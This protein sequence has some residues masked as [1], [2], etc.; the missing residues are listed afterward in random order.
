MEGMPWKFKM[1]KVEMRAFPG[2]VREYIQKGERGL[3]TSI[4]PNQRE[5]SFLFSVL[6]HSFILSSFALHIRHGCRPPASENRKIT[7][8]E[9]ITMVLRAQA[10]CYHQMFKH[11]DH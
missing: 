7:V 5:S 4:L 3:V 1:E 8:L 6:S 10:S 11:Q 9:S 2:G